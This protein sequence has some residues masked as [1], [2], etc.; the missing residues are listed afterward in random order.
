MLSHFI[1]HFLR[2]YGISG[3][4]IYIFSQAVS[5]SSS[6]ITSVAGVAAGV[7]RAEDSSD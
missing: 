3:K 1:L 5:V 6:E 2:V 4:F 7:W